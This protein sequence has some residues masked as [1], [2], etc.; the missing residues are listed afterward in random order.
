MAQSGVGTRRS[1]SRRRHRRHRQIRSGWPPTFWPVLPPVGAPP[2]ADA[3]AG[4]EAEAAL[5]KTAAKKQRRREREEA[6]SVAET[7]ISSGVGHALLQK[8]GWTSG[9]LGRRGEGIVEPVRAEGAVGKRGLGGDSEAAGSAASIVRADE[10][11]RPPAPPSS[12]LD[13]QTFE[14]LVDVRGSVAETV[15]ALA[16][17]ARGAGLEV[18]DVSLK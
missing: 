10:P 9:A 4:E 2:E 12:E 18:L 13:V 16:T 14:V 11:A 17:A 6:E 7:P 5:S 1:Q 15:A 3:G 8:M